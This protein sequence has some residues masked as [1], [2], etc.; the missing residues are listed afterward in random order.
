[1]RL[2]VVIADMGSGG[3]ESIAAQVGASALEAGD[4]VTLATT[5]GWRLAALRTRGV[6]VVTIPLATRRIGS[7]VRS[8][9]RLRRHL[10]GTSTV[11]LVHA[12][13]VRA[14][15]AARL[16]LWLLARPVGGA[17]R[18][19]VV[20]T[21]HG[22]APSR[23]LAAALLLRWV[24][25]EVV[26]VSDDVARR[27]GVGRLLGER[28][29]VIENGAVRPVLGPREQSRHDLGVPATERVVLCLARI[30]A[31]KRHDLLIEAW[32]QVGAADAVL[33]VAG[34][35]PGRAACEQRASE[36]GLDSVRFLGDRRD[37][38]RLLSASDVLV[39]PTDR[40][41]LP[42]TVLEAMAAGVAVI[43]SDVGGLRSLDR[44][45]LALVAP[46]SAPALAEQI[47][48]LLGDTDARE[49]LGAR[50]RVLAEQRF[51]PGAMTTA[52]RDLFEQVRAPKRPRGRW[53]G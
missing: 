28:L 49:A 3:A 48:R 51:A 10:R 52:Y 21:V 27:L 4:D 41:G 37:A 42:L 25:D 35:G 12:H 34:D 1:M 30:E 26:A 20:T 15:V 43:A 33:L 24:S 16:A 29:R 9:A 13:N 32:R 11:D 39:L 2:L 45:A 17:R 38:A 18:V 23:Y 40:E 14:T 46:G 6:S 53:L 47:R 7:T 8:A 36:L 44:D 5:G 19:P 31:P 50:G 22:L